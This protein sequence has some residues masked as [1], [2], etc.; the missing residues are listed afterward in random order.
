MSLRG[1]FQ[2][3]VLGGSCRI[4]TGSGSPEGAVTAGV[5]SQ[6]MQTD[7]SAGAVLWIKESG[8]GNTGWVA[9][10]S[11]SSLTSGLAKI[12]SLTV[13]DAQ[14]K[15]LPSSFQTVVAAPGS[16]KTHIFHWAT[17][18][19]FTP[20]GSY[21][22]VDAGTQQGIAVAFGDWDADASN[23]LNFTGATF[24]ARFDPF[25]PV[26][27]ATV[28]GAEYPDRAQVTGGDNKA[29]KVIAWNT[30]GD[31]TGGGA[32]N[33]LVVQVCYSTVDLATGL[34]I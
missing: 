33:S 19:L 26:P 11:A 21:T 34:L 4:K 32:S 22:N 30:G 8:S 10:A 9:M 12:E 24:F 23:F 1:F 16:G 27:D 14:F 17:G 2:D 18:A 20:S 25:K 28:L 5:G 3:L 31:Y 15:A 7:G 6:Y 29:L 13:T